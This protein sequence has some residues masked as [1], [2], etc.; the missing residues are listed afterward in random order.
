[1]AI[2]KESYAVCLRLRALVTAQEQF[3]SMEMIIRQERFDYT[4]SNGR[5]ACCCLRVWSEPGRRP[6]AI[7]TELEDNPGASVTSAAG[8]LWR[9]VW[10]YL[11]RP[12]GLLM[13][14]HY[15]RPSEHVPCGTI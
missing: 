1:L 5:R 14:E 12:E 13:V 9:R 2:H 8:L 15:S 11:E 4:D 10:E 7:V 6:V 3:R